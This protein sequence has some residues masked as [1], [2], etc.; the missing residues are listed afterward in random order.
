MGVW[1]VY[2][3]FCRSRVHLFPNSLFEIPDHPIILKHIRKQKYWTVMVSPLSDIYTA[4]LINCDCIFL[5][6]RCLKRHEFQYS[7]SP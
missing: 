3:N 2:F 5:L 4:L 6:P 1:H 7:L